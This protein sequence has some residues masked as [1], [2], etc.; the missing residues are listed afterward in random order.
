MG[1]SDNGDPAGKIILE[2]VIVAG[3]GNNTRIIANAV[4]EDPTRISDD[5]LSLLSKRETPDGARS[6]SLY[7]DQDVEQTRASIVNVD[8]DEDDIERLKRVIAK[9]EPQR[10]VS[11][12]SKRK[13]VDAPD[14]T[15]G[16]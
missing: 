2:E 1:R 10:I 3:S 7:L 11:R 15:H 16:K 8:E 14:A 5:V 13:I 4:A 12:K 9:Y 6:S